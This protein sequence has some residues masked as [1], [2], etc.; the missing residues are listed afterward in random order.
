MNNDETKD[1]GPG[2]GPHGPRSFVLTG[3]QTCQGMPAAHE[4]ALQQSDVDPTLAGSGSLTCHAPAGG[5]RES[6][7]PRPLPIVPG[8]DVLAELGRGGMGVVYLARELRLN[9]PCA[10][11]MVLAGAHASADT[12]ARF[13]QEA[14]AV[15]QLK[16]PAIVSIHHIGEVDGLPFFEMEFV[17]GGSLDKKLDGTP[18]PAAKA[19]ALIEPVALGMAG[20]HE[21]NVVHRDLKPGNVLLTADGSPK[22]ID[23]GLAKVLGSESGLTRTES[24]LGSPSYMAPEQ[25]GGK[26]RDA[27]ALA[28][29]YALG[30]I[31]YELVTGR[32]PFRGATLLETLEQ[33]KTVDPVLPT[34][35]VP[36]L[37]R[38]IE[39]IALKCLEK[40]PAKRY[41][42]ARHLAEDLAR[43]RRGEP[44]Q[45]RPVAFWERGWK[46]ARRRP[47]IAALVVALHLAL[48][49]LLGLGV[50][51]YFQ[52]RGALG[53]ATDEKNNALAAEI[54]ATTARERADAERGKAESARLEALS[55][56]YRAGISE[57]RALRAGHPPGW[58]EAALTN[59]AKLAVMP[60]ARSDVFELRTELVACLGVPD[61]QEVLQV[62]SDAG[63]LH[64][65]AISPDGRT[66]AT[67][68]GHQV[69]LW[70]MEQGRHVAVITEPR[71]WSQPEF[72]THARA[73]SFLPDGRLLF[74]TEDQGVASYDP[75][76]GTFATTPYRRGRLAARDLLRD[77][78]AKRLVIRWFDGSIDVFDGTT[79]KLVRRG[80]NDTRGLSLSTD[81]KWLA[82]EH[83]G[84]PIELQ[85]VDGDMP[86]VVF[87]RALGR[88]FFDLEFSPDG[89]LL[90][91]LAADHAVVV[92]D[93]AS[94]GE[95]LFLRGH[96]EGTTQVAFSPDNAW[97]ATS[98]ND[99][100]ARVWD[101][102]TGQALAVLPGAWFV[103]SVTFSP[104]GRRLVVGTSGNRVS[105]YEI[106]GR[107]V[108]RRL[109]GHFYGAQSL[110]F[111]PRRSLLATGADDH[112]VF[113]WDATSGEA[114]RHW[115][116]AQNAYVSA[117]AFS[118]DGE[119]LASAEGVSEGMSTYEVRVREV[120]TG[121]VRHRLSGARSGVHSLAFDSRGQHL[122]SGDESGTVVMWD[123]AT[124][125]ETR[126]WVVSE[127]W[128][129]TLAFLDD[130]KRIFV[131]MMGGG[132]GYFDIEGEG[133]PRAARVD[134]P[135][136]GSL[137]LPDGTCALVGTTT[138]TLLRF[139][140]P[141]LEETGRLEKAHERSVT[142][143]AL[144][145]DG[146]LLATGGDDRR[147]VLR[148]PQ[149][150]Q[151]L[152]RLPEWTGVIKGLA[153]DATGR[154]LAFVG[155]D[156]DVAL[157]DVDEVRRGLAEAGLF[158]EGP[159]SHAPVRPNTRSVREL[160]PGNADP[161]ELAEARRLL[162]S[163]T[164]A[165]LEGRLEEALRDLPLTRDRYRE[166]LRARPGDPSL[167]QGLSI[168]VGFL[169][170]ALRDAKRP[171]EALPAALE[172]V[173]LLESLAVK[174][175][176]DLYNLAC[177]LAQIVAL[178]EASGAPLPD[179]E[180]ERTLARA[181]DQ[182]TRSVERGLGNFAQMD[183]D[184]DLDPLRGRADFQALM[185][186]RTFP[187]D[188]FEA[189][190]SR[191]ALSAP[192]GRTYPIGIMWVR[193]PRGPRIAQIVPG[194]PADGHPGLDVGDL[195]VGIENGVT[196]EGL[197]PN[198]LA[199]H[200]RGPL[201]STVRVV[202]EKAATGER[203]VHEMT[204]GP[205]PAA[206]DPSRAQLDRAI[207]ERP[208]QASTWFER[209]SFLA[210]RG[211]WQEALSD[212]L[213]V[214]EL[215]PNESAPWLYAAPLYLMLGDEKGH[216]ALAVAMRAQFAEDQRA[217]SLERTAK[218]G[219]MRDPPPED[220]AALT[221]LA[222]A[223]LRLDGSD[224]LTHWFEL[225]RGM[226]AYR[227]RDD[228]T[229]VLMLGRS[230]GKTKDLCRVAALAY[231]AMARHRLGQVDAARED[232]K[233]VKERLGQYGR[234]GDYGDAW[235]DWLIADLARR[236]ADQL[237]H[238][239]GD[240]R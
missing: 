102:R 2:L 56:T 122:V 225:V 17:E 186:D 10:L 83:Q 145:P 89:S 165:F 6:G 46:W 183:S 85:S 212:L 52:I 36:G 233:E 169:S 58:R 101:A 166:L 47:A 150:F 94:R 198:Q 223:A 41:P 35:L 188:P 130:D 76:S 55:E 226:A 12:M 200:I 146:R 38:D 235:P 123:L 219:L 112:C 181:V 88:D 213:R 187:R 153:F 204:R 116:K 215:T 170:S 26:T 143:I 196:F 185:L 207:E 34:R 172:S 77:R 73:L 21:Q 216:R 126:R 16:H 37:P 217:P 227:A 163:A 138:G 59:L 63:Q 72:R 135:I 236:E 9:R 238:E 4:E 79:G 192:P 22:V 132:C 29:V 162:S 117:L 206:P 31:L 214:I 157:W 75:A 222:E 193:S 33:V 141:D 208:N 93:V 164:Q 108:R 182:L 160:R 57:V 195:A 71:P 67:L 167:V 154:W 199:S 27:G 3:D 161:V 197:N 105:V 97:I 32:P 240:E 239:P 69:H 11:K 137:V 86:K 128:I 104:D 74:S 119:L 194:G 231:R 176:L 175:P 210:R 64:S 127:G 229:A 19:A 149:T 190:P 42:S 48:A 118:P 1:R 228:E 66:L 24:V 25:A 171:A 220:L 28:D 209:G 54:K 68:A 173:A 134:D 114:L 106:D 8:Y 144:S 110:A 40:D 7:G 237:L 103:E 178:G 147:V 70:D 179:D 62:R 49:A 159:R 230:I 136:Y 20:A 99:H 124:A 91:S 39:T 60:T 111:H 90:A 221:E 30:A 151:P 44:I 115:D 51:S 65:V 133:R 211:E 155:A 92:W 98:S 82:T 120:A 140:L 148:D 78:E 121:R 189:G 50:V 158:W 96:N 109:A 129:N 14:Q 180:R 202:F 95:R 84:R 224:G 113:F 152:L 234:P 13:L 18:W 203:V 131:G 15:A 168:S 5:P 125:R 45:A 23:F 156:A 87:E 218:V 142:A 100:T 139:S 184:A 177:S 61:I 107:E 80:P 191:V 205:F 81:G 174:R 232:L 53:K 201:G 43:F